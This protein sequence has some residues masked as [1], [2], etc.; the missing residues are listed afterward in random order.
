M[1]EE[2]SPREKRRQKEETKRGRQ[3]YLMIS[4]IV[5]FV[6]VVAVCIGYTNY[7]ITKN[8]DIWCE[9]LKPFN[10]RVQS[11]PNL[12]EEQKQTAASFRV[13]YE[14]LEC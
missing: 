6:S 11:V 9:F 10:A 7:S 4:V 3:V 13:L 12:T 2:D 5:S 14:K 8:N 1:T